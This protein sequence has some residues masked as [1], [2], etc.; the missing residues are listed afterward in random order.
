MTRAFIRCGVSTIPILFVTRE[1][2]PEPREQ[3]G[4]AVAPL[5]PHP[6]TQPPGLR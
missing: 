3:E 5:A 6:R 4:A 1:A 2:A